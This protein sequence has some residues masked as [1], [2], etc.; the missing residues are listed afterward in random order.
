MGAWKRSHCWTRLGFMLGVDFKKLA[1]TA[2]PKLPSSYPPPPVIISPARRYHLQACNC[3]VEMSMVVGILTF[4]GMIN[5]RLGW[6][7]HGRG[8]DVFIMLI[9]VKM[10]TAVGS[11]TFGSMVSFLPGWGDHNWGFHASILLS[12]DK[13]IWLFICC[14]FLR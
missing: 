12:D 2:V 8:Y 14:C 1:R 7:E 13:K 3:N 5:F 10:S 4:V 11:L 6:I 9:N